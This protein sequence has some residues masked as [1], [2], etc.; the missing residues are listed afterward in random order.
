MGWIILALLF[1]FT[2]RMSFHLFQKSSFYFNIRLI[3]SH[4][5]GSRTADIFR[6]KLFTVQHSEWLNPGHCIVSVKGSTDN[7]PRPGVSCVST[8]Q[9]PQQLRLFSLQ[10][11]LLIARGENG[12]LLCSLWWFPQTARLLRCRESKPCCTVREQEDGSRLSY[13][14]NTVP[15]KDSLQTNAA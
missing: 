3:N 12:L 13:Y 4:D 1:W 5:T 9:T 14:H 7:S 10:F 11:H 15:Q 6:Q 8:Q 2:S